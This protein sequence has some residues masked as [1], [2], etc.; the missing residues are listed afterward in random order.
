ML[1]DAIWSLQNSPGNI[2]KA[3]NRLKE[4]SKPRYPKQLGW[5]LPALCL[6]FEVQRSRW[7]QLLKTTTFARLKCLLLYRQNVT[8]SSCECNKVLKVFQPWCW[9]LRFLG[10]VKLLHPRT[11]E[12]AL[13]SIEF[14]WTFTC[15]W[16]LMCKWYLHMWLYI[17]FQEIHTVVLLVLD[18]FK[19][20]V[21]FSMHFDGKMSQYSAFV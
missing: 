5:V 20:R 21:W 15:K 6:Y 12:Q 4:I 11:W 8:S 17:N 14:N 16:V 7:L 19:T 10:A 13:V 1:S 18:C 3:G 2:K 9:R